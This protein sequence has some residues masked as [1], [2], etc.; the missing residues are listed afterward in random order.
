MTHE[1]GDA[2]SE[3]SRNPRDQTAERPSP[4]SASSALEVA[5]R[6]LLRVE[7]GAYAT[8]A[9]SGELQ[10]ARLTDAGRALCTELVYGSL[11]RQVRIERALSALAPRGLHRLDTQVRALL[12]LGAYQLLFTRVPPAVAVSQIVDAVRRLRGPVLAGFV[13]AILRRLGREGEPPSPPLPGSEA[14]DRKF[15]A[16]L[17]DRHGLPAFLVLELLAQQDR[18]ETAALCEALET[19][20]PLWLRLNP[21]RGSREKALQALAAEGF[22]VAS[23]VAPAGLPEALRI[24]GGHPF[25]G[26]A[27]GEG[28]FLAQDLGAQLVARL[29]LADTAD[30]PLVLPDGALLD[31]CAGVGGKTTHLAALT[32][33]RRAIDAADASPRKLALCREHA[34]RL[35]CGRVA[36]LE[37]DLLDPEALARHLRPGYAAVLLDA[38][39]SGVG[40]LRR[41]PEARRRLLPSQ[42]TELSAV[43]KRLLENLAPYVLPQGVLVYAVCSFLLTEGPART[44]AFLQDHPGW[45]LLPPPLHEPPWQGKP[46]PLRTLPHLHDADGFYAVRFLRTH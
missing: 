4:P 41:H 28:F 46:W 2:L 39:C 45:K 42:V 27:F 15:A 40:V 3:D 35:G 22:D 6:V 44:A 23:A 13:N 11:R 12:Q 21:L 8:L 25:S 38:P 31:A 43:Q 26:A 36:T 34:H 24:Q 19:P 29:L 5:R 16:A 30:G 17:A 7:S 37:V 9:L 18:A 20:A 32:D 33:N 14:T 1:A 10:R